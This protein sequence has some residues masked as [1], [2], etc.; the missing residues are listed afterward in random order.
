MCAFAAR[1]SF[2]SPPARLA[3][4][5][6][7]LG[8]G[9]PS[10]AMTPV[11]RRQEAGCKEATVNTEDAGKTPFRR[12]TGSASGHDDAALQAVPAPGAVAGTFAAEAT[13]Q[14][15]TDPGATASTKSLGM[16]RKAEEA[17]QS[18]P[19]LLAAMLSNALTVGSPGL[20]SWPT[21]PVPEGVGHSG[22]AGIACLSAGS[23]TA[24]A[25]MAACKG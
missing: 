16:G 11:P 21:Q 13:S 1:V 7:P 24:G 2:A 15:G 23:A 9:T 3:A 25:P 14:V 20:A 10:A 22:G 17:T 8:A 19:A 12:S 5:R 18:M 4:G 6:H